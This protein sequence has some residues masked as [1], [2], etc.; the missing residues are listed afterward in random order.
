M[1]RGRPKSPTPPTPVLVRFDPAQLAAIDA[2][3]GA[4]KRTAKIHA[5]IAAGLAA[6]KGK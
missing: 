1:P 6:E 2:W 3:P 4:S 5:L